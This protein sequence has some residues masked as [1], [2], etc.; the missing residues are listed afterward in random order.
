MPVK[1]IIVFCLLPALLLLNIPNVL[2][3]EKFSYIIGPEDVLDVSVW[4]HP[5][6]NRVVTVRPDGKIS[7][8]LIGDVDASGLTPAELDE[9][10]TKRLSKYVQNPEVTVIVTTVG[11]RSK[12]VLILGQVAKPGPYLV[13]KD[14]TVLEAIAMAG[15]YT[16]S[17]SLEKVTI[18]RRRAGESP[19]VME[20]NL[21]KV[22]LGGNTTE[23][24]SVM[25]GDIVYVPK[26]RSAWDIFDRWF[27]RGLLPI[28]VFFVAIDTLTRD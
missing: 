6:L 8:S 9:A 22:I 17:A 15:S 19:R 21:K 2:P 27:V 26:K 18:T 13:G 1:K 7:F 4:Q 5:E 16:E 3:Q 10:I 11:I 28:M 25:P 12:Q 24:F 23:D 14:V 20:A